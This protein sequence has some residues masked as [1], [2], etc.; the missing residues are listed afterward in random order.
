[1]AWDPISKLYW[2]WFAGS[3]AGALYRQHQE[4]QH[5][6]SGACD[7][8]NVL[9]TP[10]GVHGLPAHLKARLLRAYMTDMP[11]VGERYRALH[12]AG[13]AAGKEALVK[14]MLDEIQLLQ[15]TGGV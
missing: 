15:S 3:Q 10:E 5:H 6:A 14:E 7:C 11:E 4:H 13:D 12:R 2:S 9:D 8:P 1:M